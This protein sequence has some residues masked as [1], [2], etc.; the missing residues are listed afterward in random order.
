MTIAKV[1]NYSIFSCYQFLLVFQDLANHLRRL[2][3][4]RDHKPT[5]YH[6]NPPVSRTTDPKAPPKGDLLVLKAAEEQ[7]KEV[8]VKVRMLIMMEASAAGFL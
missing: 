3:H 2:L 7:V 6:H 8:K 1:K 5:Y 4:L